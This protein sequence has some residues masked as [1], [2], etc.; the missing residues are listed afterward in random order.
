M[1]RCLLIVL[2]FGR[3]LALPKHWMRRIFIPSGTKLGIWRRILF[4]PTPN[5][6]DL[7][8][9]LLYGF[10][11]HT[12]AS[13]SVNQISK[14]SNFIDDKTKEIKNI[15]KLNVRETLYFAKL[16]VLT[17]ISK[18]AN[19]DKNGIYLIIQCHKNSETSPK[20]RSKKLCWIWSLT[21]V[22]GKKW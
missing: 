21:P 5:I 13:S 20:R 4:L 7:G 15:F 22:Y 2:K 9:K 10:S 3:F 1:S 11:H 17:Q 16:K 14:L 6:T 8:S 18:N 19:T 12:R